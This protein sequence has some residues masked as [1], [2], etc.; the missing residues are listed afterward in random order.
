MSVGVASLSRGG[1]SASSLPWEG[2][3]FCLA[4]IMDL[5]MHWHGAVAFSPLPVVP[6]GERVLAFSRGLVFLWVLKQESRL[7]LGGMCAI[8]LTMLAEGAP[9]LPHRPLNPTALSTPSVPLIDPLSKKL[10]A[11]PHG[12]IS[13]LKISFSSHLLSLVLVGSCAVSA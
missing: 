1:L 5:V 11:L 12:L 7:G 4:A 10:P 3:S 6:V 8:P 13:S 2:F 9:L